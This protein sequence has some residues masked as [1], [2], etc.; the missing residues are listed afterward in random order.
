MRR[1]CITSRL[2]GIGLLLLLATSAWAID[3]ETR[4]T[5]AELRLS[6]RAYGNQTIKMLVR[7]VPFL[8]KQWPDERFGLSLGQGFDADRVQGQLNFV[9]SPDFSEQLVA[10]FRGARDLRKASLRA[11]VHTEMIDNQIYHIAHIRE[12][13]IVASLRQEIG[14]EYKWHNQSQDY[15]DEETLEAG[16]KREVYSGGKSVG[17]GKHSDSPASPTPGLDQANSAR[18]QQAVFCRKHLPGLRT[19]VYKLKLALTECMGMKFTSRRN[20]VDRP[21]AYS[22]FTTVTDAETLENVIN[23][24]SADYIYLPVGIYVLDNPIVIKRKTPLYIHGANR[25]ST[26]LVSQDPTQPLF[27]IRQGPLVNFTNL[28]LDPTGEISETVDARAVLMVR[29]SPTD[30][31][32]VE[33]RLT[34]SVLEANGRGKVRIQGS[35]ISPG[36]HTTAPILVDHPMGDLLI[37]GGN[38]S[39]GPAEP[40]IASD[41]QFHIWVKRGRL[42]IYGT[43]VQAALGVADFRIDRRSNLGPHVIADVR[44]EGSSGYPTG[45]PSTL[46]TVP[47]TGRAVDV[48]MKLNSATGLDPVADRLVDYNA[49]GTLWMIGNNLASKAK[50]LVVGSAPG[51]TIVAIGNRLE[52][53]DPIQTTGGAQEIEVH[54]LYR[55]DD[56]N[57]VDHGLVKFVSP[58]IYFAD[59]PAIPVIPDVAIPDPI[60]RPV[61]DLALPGM[62]DVTVFGATPNN[63]EDDDLAAIQSALNVPGAGRH[64]YFP[65]GTYHVSDSIKYNHSTSTVIQRHGGWLAGAGSGV[66]KIVRV[67]GG[68]VFESDGMAYHT[69]QGLTF[70]TQAWEGD[71]LLSTGDVNFRIENDVDF[72]HASQQIIFHDVIFDGGQTALGIGLNSKTQCS[73]NMMIDVEFRNAQYGMGIGGFNALANIVYDGSWVDN[74]INVGHQ[75]F[76]HGGTWAILGGTAVGTAFQDFSIIDTARGIWYHEGFDSDAPAIYNRDWTSAAYSVWFERSQLGLETV[77]AISLKFAGTAGPIFLRSSVGGAGLDLHLNQSNNASFALKLYSSI[78]L[79][80]QA[81]EGPAGQI[82]Q[83]D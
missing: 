23:N 75:E 57:D 59:R 79:W 28:N 47:S 64:V 25:S 2:C 58:G 50:T 36:G 67:D 46:L 65:A 49:A 48:L 32:L 22:E 83:L 10:D 68:P 72:G 29:S 43:G 16:R 6:P 18:R 74:Y 17:I 21:V 63:D 82:D 51:A 66:T 73:E 71:P 39:N 5:V 41:D 35:D 30:L 42:R 4:V 40:L 70:Q 14:G 62:L 7:D 45:H 77:A 24:E 12:I 69:V 20:A 78:P 33:I 56:K 37:V 80:D 26:R 27:E 34:T 60:L 31:E 1:V 76:G 8:I 15:Q 3:Y 38:I 13:V 52:A 53:T 55:V 44:S 11:D 61:V 19:S 9:L 54:N 81:N